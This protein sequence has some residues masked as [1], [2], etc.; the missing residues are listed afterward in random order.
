M[1]FFRYVST[2]ETLGI[3]IKMTRKLKGW[4]TSYSLEKRV[5]G[6]VVALFKRQS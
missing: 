6:E 4:R 1:L 2:D 5:A 3:S